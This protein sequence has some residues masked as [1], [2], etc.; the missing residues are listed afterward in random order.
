MSGDARKQVVDGLE[1]EAAVQEVEPGGTVDVHGG[2]EHFL[3]EGLVRAEVGGAHGEVREGDLDVQRGGGHVGDEDEE[4]AG[5]GR[6]DAA[7]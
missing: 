7:V 4:E 3:G 1:L 6:R 2:A 5:R